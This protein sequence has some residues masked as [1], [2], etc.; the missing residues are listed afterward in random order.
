MKLHY[1]K[2]PSGN[3]GDDL[4]PWLWPR[5]MPEFFNDDPD[6]LF[7]GIGTLLNHRLPDTPVKH[8]FGSGAGYG[9]VMSVNNRT[10]VHALRGPL[11]AKVIG[12]DPAKVITDAGILVRALHPP[13][14]KV[15][16]GVGMIFTGHSLAQYDWQSVCERAGIRFISCH[17]DVERVLQ[18]LETCE[19]VICEAMH[20]AI[21]SDAL[22]IPWIP[23]SLYGEV[24]EFKWK[25]WLATLNLPYRPTCTEPLYEVRHEPLGTALRNG[26]KRAL[27]RTGLYPASAVPHKHK[28]T[29]QKE[30]GSVLDILT[31]FKS[32]DA[33]LS[34]EQLTES[35]TSR[36][37]EALERFRREYR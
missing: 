22:R 6:E 11:T 36:Y 28:A 18:E 27:S 30:E 13:A 8:I 5:L 32:S 35:L 9:D 26:V 37:L 17:W 24:L 23:V 15:K 29:G 7:V 19:F 4:N 12:A 34:D 10:H 1:F 2:D 33:Y 3:F 20:G 14:N 31:R 21:V 16:T 25:D